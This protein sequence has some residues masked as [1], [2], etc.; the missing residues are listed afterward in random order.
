MAHTSYIVC[1]I[2]V[3]QGLVYNMQRG[4]VAI[5]ILLCRKSTAL[6]GFILEQRLA[7]GDIIEVYKMLWNMCIEKDVFPL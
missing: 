2:R 7:K 5:T 3:L 4:T 6:G 1:K